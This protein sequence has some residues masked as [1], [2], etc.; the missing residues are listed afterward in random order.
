MANM[1]PKVKTLPIV[2]D[3]SKYQEQIEKLIKKIFKEALYIPL[4]KLLGETQSTLENS[5]DALIKAIRTGRVT[6]SQGVFRGRFTAGVSK[7][8]KALGATWADGVFRVR[9]SDL[10]TDVRSAI[11]LSEARFQ[12]KLESIQKKLDEVL[13]EDIAG[14]IDVTEIFSKEIY[15]VTKDIDETLKAITVMPEL[16]D[17]NRREIASG[18]ANNMKLTIQD[19]ANDEIQKLRLDVSNNAF[20]GIRYEALVKDIQKSY[21]VTASKAKFL[22]RQE[23]NLLLTE[24]KKTRYLEAGVDEYQWIC[25]VGSPAH[26]VRDQHKKLDRQFFSWH[27]PPITSEPG[28]PERRNHPGQDF[29]CRCRAKPIVRF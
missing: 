17:Q 10:P 28:E 27:N 14:K 18:W 25:V 3:D 22:A 7:E 13:P 20:R 19:F 9:L 15:R 2:D 5:R 12:K 24:L 26:P 6:H 11:E 21:G 23:T 8:L 16:S 4:I 1:N 29:N